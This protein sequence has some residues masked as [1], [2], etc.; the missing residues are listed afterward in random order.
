MELS[1]KVKV[2]VLGSSFSSYLKLLKKREDHLAWIN[3]NRTSFELLMSKKDKLLA[4]KTVE[5]FDCVVRR[6]L[7]A[8]QYYICFLKENGVYKTR[9]NLSI[10]EWNKFVSLENEIRRR[11]KNPQEF[12]LSVEG[13]STRYMVKD[14]ERKYY[15]L[16]E[17]DAVSYS[18]DV[19]KDFPC[20]TVTTLLPN[21]SDSEIICQLYAYLMDLSM[22]SQECEGCEKDYPSQLDHACLMDWEVRIEDE[23][24]SHFMKA[25]MTPLFKARLNRVFGIDLK[26]EEPDKQRIQHILKEGQRP[27][28]EALMRRVCGLEVYRKLQPYNNDVNFP[29]FITT[30]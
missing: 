7:F 12:N 10:P 25:S 27:E 20:L 24:D 2:C 9:M 29:K 28:F 1:D 4:G 26:D 18:K 17:E 22:K 13:M 30:F 3:L 14:E 15:F 23:F 19:L 6:T 21:P 8:G 5:L 16:D 11:L